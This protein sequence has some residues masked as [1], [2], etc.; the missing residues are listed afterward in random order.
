MNKRILTAVLVISPIL[1]TAAPLPLTYNWNGMVHTGEM[2]V[3]DSASGYRSISD[4]GLT[5]LVDGNSLQSTVVGNTGLEYDFV[6]S[7]SA[8]DTVFL[9]I[10]KEWEPVADGDDRGIQ[11]SWDPTGGT[12][13]LSS[14]QNVLP[15][16]A[17]A[18]SDFNLGFLYNISNG[19]GEFDATLQFDSEEVTVTLGAPDWFGAPAVPAPNAGVAVQSRLNGPV[20]GTRWG[21][22]EARDIA[23]FGPAL[24]LVEATIT[25]DSLLADLSFDIVGRTLTGISFDELTGVDVGLREGALGVY[26][27]SLSGAFEASVPMDFNGHTY[28]RVFFDR[29]IFW[30]DAKDIAAAMTLNGMQGHLA[31]ITSEAE[32]QFIINN[33]EVFTNTTGGLE[34]FGP[35][36]GAFCD[37]SVA[38]TGGFCR[39]VTNYAWVTGEAFTY[40][41]FGTGEPSGDGFGNFPDD[42][43]VE[44]LRVTDGWND[45]RA[46]ENRVFSFIVEFAPASV[47]EPGSLALLALGLAGLGF[48]RRRVH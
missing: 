41:G 14:W 28:N 25:A 45:S 37:V 23:N 38:V 26:A 32:D 47:P 15:S 17:V 48:A 35:W 43:G 5:V 46:R 6:T 2:S 12:A 16:P 29:P 31:V 3:P 8:V 44:Y 19:G 9:G 30:A 13:A 40:N 33:F 20:S 24:N 39:Q 7:S 18:S 42:G 10:R 11:P 4:R 21:G 36:I 27:A 22:V 1:A 34:G